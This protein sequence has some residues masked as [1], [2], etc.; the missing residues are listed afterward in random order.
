MQ[1]MLN[2]GYA[3]DLRYEQLKREIHWNHVTLTLTGTGF[4]VRAA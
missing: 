2:A 4:H 3:N 1:T